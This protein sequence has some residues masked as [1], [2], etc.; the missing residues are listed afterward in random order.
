MSCLVVF[1]MLSHVFAC[2]RMFE[3]GAGE[4][5]RTRPRGQD[6]SRKVLAVG[7]SKQRDVS[8]R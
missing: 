4:A 1:R 3:H 6:K 5:E 7:R 8:N 2:F